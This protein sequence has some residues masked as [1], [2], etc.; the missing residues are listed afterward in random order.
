MLRAA[1]CNGTPIATDTMSYSTAMFIQ[2]IIIKLTQPLVK[3]TKMLMYQSHKIIAQ[4]DKAAAHSDVF[5]HRPRSYPHAV[6]NSAF[7]APARPRTTAARPRSARSART[8][9]SSSRRSKQINQR[10]CI[11]SSSSAASVVW[12]PTDDEAN[13]GYFASPHGATESCDYDKD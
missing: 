2:S 4:S 5:I 6:A 8:A 13:S 10:R 7:P 12:I 3:A 1:L 11:P 9:S